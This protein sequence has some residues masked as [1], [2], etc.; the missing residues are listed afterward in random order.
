MITRHVK[1][2]GIMTAVS[3]ISIGGTRDS[4]GFTAADIPIV[5]NPLTGKPY[6]PGSSIKGKMRSLFERS[7]VGNSRNGEP[8]GC[9]KKDC[10]VCKL[11]GAH[12]NTKAASG[13]SRLIFRDANLTPEFDSVEESVLIEIIGTAIDRNTGNTLRTRECVT[14][15]TEFEYEI[16]ILVQDGDDEK[17][18][19]S[20]VE[21][22]LKMIE[23]TGLGGMI[24]NGC[25]QV[26]F[27]VG[28]DSYHVES[29]ELR[30]FLKV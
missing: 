29:T 1:I 20:A 14:K 4:L 2:T 6:I 13:P 7:G 15:G 21:S 3:G 27:H 8:C 26:N 28:E 5:R 11:F 17:D 9:G 23:R 12:K 25:G 18:M 30:K 19:I 10:I 22:G 16:D 24:S